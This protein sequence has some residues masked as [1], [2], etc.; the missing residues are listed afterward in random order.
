[1]IKNTQLKRRKKRKKEQRENSNNR[2]LPN[3]IKKSYQITVKQEWRGTF[4]NLFPLTTVLQ[5]HTRS[6]SNETK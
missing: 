5:H 3:H 4:L 2:V 6:S 1:M